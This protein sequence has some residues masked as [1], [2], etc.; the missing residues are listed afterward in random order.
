MFLDKQQV[1]SCMSSSGQ[2]E[3]VIVSINLSLM[4]FPTL[5]DM[6]PW[7]EEHAFTSFPTVYSPSFP[8]ETWERGCSLLSVLLTMCADFINYHR[9]LNKSPQI[10]LPADEL[11]SR[12]RIWAMTL[13]RK[14][15]KVSLFSSWKFPLISFFLLLLLIYVFFHYPRWIIVYPAYLNSRRTV[16]Q[17]R[18]VPKNKVGI[19]TSCPVV[20]RNEDVL[21]NAVKA[22]F[23]KHEMS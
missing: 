13:H 3:E 2:P 20:N 16:E 5:W 9:R 4:K 10:F 14:I 1:E 23:M 17:G 8:E 11:H 18:R 21:C 12:W 19:T 22:G 7:K 6:N 15:G